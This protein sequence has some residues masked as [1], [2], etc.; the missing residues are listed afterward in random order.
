MLEAALGSKICVLKINV[1]G[2]SLAVQWLRL[3]V[4]NTVGTGSIPGQG[5][6][7]PQVAWHGQKK[8]INLSDH[9]LE[10]SVK[11]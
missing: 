1:L 10:R 7:I 5:T 6:R 8:K 4:S 2:T 3:H 9:H 11:R